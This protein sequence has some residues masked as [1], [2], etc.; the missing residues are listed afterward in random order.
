MNCVLCKHGVTKPGRTTVTLERNGTL[1]VIRD[2]PADI[3]VECG[4]YYLDEPTIR[5]VL[6]WAGDAEKRHAEVEVMRYVA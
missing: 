1:V 3:C 4:E 5:R 2:V 6:A